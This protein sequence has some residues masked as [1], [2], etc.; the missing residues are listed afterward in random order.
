MM[1]SGDDVGDS[2]EAPSEPALEAEVV[3]AA[4]EEVKPAAESAVVEPASA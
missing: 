2:A 1:A 3:G 4:E